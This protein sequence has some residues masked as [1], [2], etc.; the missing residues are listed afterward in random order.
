MATT[1]RN[2]SGVF[3]VLSLLFVLAGALLLF[4]IQSAE[5]AI[6]NAAV[7]F[8]SCLAIVSG[9]RY[10]LLLRKD[11]A[12]SALYSQLLF[13]SA[14]LGLTLSRLDGGIVDANPE[15]AR[16]VGYSRDKVRTLS[17]Q[18]ITPER[19]FESDAFSNEQ[20]LAHGAY[21]PVEKE[22]IRADGTTVPVRVSGRLV[23]QKAKSLI[24]SS[25]EDITALKQRELQIENHRAHLEDVLAERSSK[26]ADSENRLRAL[27]DAMPDMIFRLDAQGYYLDYHVPSNTIAAL[28][29]DKIIGANIDNMPVAKK[30]LEMIRYC[31]RQAI[32]TRQLQRCQYSFLLPSGIQIQEEARFV[33]VDRNEV[34]VIAQDITEKQR[35]TDELRRERNLVTSLVQTA[36]V[37]WLVL[38]A[39]GRVVQFNQACEKITGYKQKNIVGEYFWDYLVVNEDR[40]RIKRLYHQLQFDVLSNADEYYWVGRNGQKHLISWSNS[41]LT[42]ATGDVEYIAAVGIDVT[43]QR[44]N[45][46]ALKVNQQ[47]LLDDKVHAENAC[48]SLRDAIVNLRRD[49]ESSFASA[50]P[51]DELQRILQRL[52]EIESVQSVGHE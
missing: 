23:Q 28:D 15:F 24:W 41:V 14:P 37:L 8:F 1:W 32:A 19:F 7:I 46:L 48:R 42:N 50:D 29:K 2:R 45:E 10:F 25:V 36:N 18:A 39:Q 35:A 11:I 20:L 52:R 38:D 30:D 4:V 31:I 49:A 26:L 5:H 40:E 33:A 12:A 3:L 47:Q 51:K 43:A 27:L 16:I 34:V 13:N 9:L 17:L 22:F 6:R 44:H 21:G